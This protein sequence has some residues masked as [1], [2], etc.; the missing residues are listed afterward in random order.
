MSPTPAV[1]PVPTIAQRVK[2]LRGRKGWSAE[3]LG[4]ALK[5]E[6]V[7]WDRFTVANLEKG[8]RQNVTVVELLALAKVLDVALVNLLVPVNDAPY[9]VTPERVE[10]SDAVR[11]WVRGQKPLPG[12]DERTFLTEV[13]VADMRVN[14][15]QRQ[16]VAGPVVGGIESIRGEGD[17]HGEHREAPER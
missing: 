15:R 10:D 16:G 12:M 4:N 14:Y 6:G 7:K 3:D 13:S 1:G 8:K 5:D 11:A 17:D 9:Q 2:A